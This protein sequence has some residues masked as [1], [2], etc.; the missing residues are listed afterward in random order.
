MQLCDDVIHMK[1]F[2]ETIVE[3]FGHANPKTSG[4]SLFQMIET[5][6]I[7]AHF[8]EDRGSAHF[9]VFSCLWYDPDAVIAFTLQHF[10]GRL[11][12][13]VFLERR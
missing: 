2:G 8:S 13:Q 4:F 12:H 7:T 6:N 10:G 3:H 5:S 1:R 9:D 11:R